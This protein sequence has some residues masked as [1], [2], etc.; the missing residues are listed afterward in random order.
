MYELPESQR[1]VH[2][3]SLSAQACDLSSG[4][5]S[6][7]KA[8]RRWWPQ[9]DA[10]PA[11]RSDP[12]WTCT[13]D[14]ASHKLDGQLTLYTRCHARH[15][16]AN[17]ISDDARSGDQE[18][19]TPLETPA[20]PRSESL[21]MPEHLE[22]LRMLYQTLP[23]IDRLEYI[24][25]H[26]GNWW[27]VWR[28]A[29]NLLW[30]DMSD[31]SLYDFALRA[32][33]AGHPAL[34]GSLLV[35][36]AFSV[37]DYDTYL[38][39]IERHLLYHDD[40]AG[41]DHGLQCL[42]GLG[43][44]LFSGLQARRAWM[45]FRRANSLLQIRGIHRSHQSSTTLTS[46]FWQLF[47]ADRWL[48]LIVGLPYSVPDTLCNVKV[49]SIE[50]I[51]IATHHHRRLAILTGR[52]I[53]CVQALGTHDLSK[54]VSISEQIDAVN[55]TLPHGYLDIQE[56]TACEDPTERY[57]RVFRITQVHQLRSYLHIP[58]FLQ[59]TDGITREYGRAICVASSESFLTAYLFVC[60]ED[61]ER[62]KIDN[63][64]KLTGFSA[65]TA[66]VILLLHLLDVAGTEAA[67]DAPKRS[68]IKRTVEA[69]ENCSNR[70]PKSLS[71]QCFTAL[72]T[73]ILACHT[74]HDEGVH[75]ID[76]PYFGQ[77]SIRPKSQVTVEFQSVV[78]A[79]PIVCDTQSDEAPEYSSQLPNDLFEL[80]SMFDDIVWD[81]E[82]SLLAEYVS[83]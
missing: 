1:C 7:E 32:L 55:S 66:A 52:V 15:L 67:C 18:E 60:D 63:N 9:S 68:L 30:G 58:L 40:L 71:G 11:T 12:D 73:L 26:Q 45:V 35:C 20:P 59:R 42:M 47:H 3:P 2:T 24:L 44:G 77:I 16:P 48:S 79:C 57:T 65:F 46:I 27:N 10:I 41:S 28:A 39:P 37:E 36:L 38:V 34:I 49:L 22:V 75:K 13:A 19:F 6:L 62:A 61:R 4:I 43:L 17:Q 33:D 70:Q 64:I 29:Y 53:D 51:G 8:Y 50:D 25:Q 76:L 56:I 69:L 81:Y 54:V 83:L 21:S 5:G 78:N 74:T 80:P 72:T 82:G 23:S 31:D 14:Q